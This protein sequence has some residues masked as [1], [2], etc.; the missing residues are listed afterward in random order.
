MFYLHF[1]TIDLYIIVRRGGK[2]QM[3]G[4]VRI[5]D[6]YGEVERKKEYRW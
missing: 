5:I 3:I 6:L 1:I 4:R 2:I